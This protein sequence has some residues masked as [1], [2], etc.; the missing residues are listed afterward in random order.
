MRLR[1]PFITRFLLALSAVLAMM[2]CADEFAESIVGNNAGDD[3]NSGCYLCFQVL[4]NSD[5]SQTRATTYD[6]EHS[7]EAKDGDFV[8]GNEELEQK[9]DLRSSFMILFDSGGNLFAEKPIRQLMDKALLEKDGYVPHP[10]DNGYIE[11]G[12]MTKIYP[13]LKAKTKEEKWPRQCLLVLNAP[14]MY[15]KLTKMQGENPTLEKILEIVWDGDTENPEKIG[16]TSAGFF[17]MTNAVYVSDEKVHVAAQIEDKHIELA[18]KIAEKRDDVDVI[19][20]DPEDEELKKLGDKVIVV[21]PKEMLRIRV[22]RMVAKFSFA[23]KHENKHSD[24]FKEEEGVDKDLYF[25]PTR[26]H[27]LEPLVFF[28]GLSEDGEIIYVATHHW[29][30]R[31]TGWGINALETKNHLFKQIGN[32]TNVKE[33]GG[34]FDYWND[35]QHYRSYWSEDPHYGNGDKYP[36]QYRGAVE[37]GENEDFEY[38]EKGNSPL[39]NYSYGDFISQTYPL[40]DETKDEFDRIV[41]TP[42]NTYGLDVIGQDLDNRTNL[43]AGT[44][45]IVTAQLEVDLTDNDEY[46][47]QDWY[48]DR[49][50]IYYKSERDCFVAFAHSFNQLLKSQES[51][52][53]PLYNWGHGGYK[54]PIKDWIAKPNKG[55]DVENEGMKYMLYYEDKPLTNSFL[56]K[57]VNDTKDENDQYIAGHIDPDEFTREYGNLTTANIL[58]GDSKLLPW[59]ENADGTLR[60]KIKPCSVDEEGNVY[61]SGSTVLQI[62]EKDDDSKKGGNGLVEEIIPGKKRTSEYD[63]SDATDD[64]IKSLFYDWVGAVDRF[65]QGKMYY[66]APVLHNGVNKKKECQSQKTLGD[67]GVVRN[68]W[69]QFQLS[70]II[71][72]GI[73]VDDPTKPIV[74]NPV[75]IDDVINFTVKI[76]DWHR[77]EWNVPILD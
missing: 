23:N 68:N 66:A 5:G 76:I 75:S 6:D 47:V 49:S 8:H 16:R 4:A 52:K 69:Y 29:R 53:Y 39:K 60:L 44:H 74:P 3:D 31:V 7:D 54:F 15:E 36:W 71:N 27:K 43:L 64:D 70:D 40:D 56:T 9:I 67:Y 77:F 2:S 42:E 17:T 1:K 59:F 63:G 57:L 41:Y 11:A 10:D 13:N 19:V 28:E 61:K 51:M 73:P 72:I 30:I 55:Y 65:K 50:G 14:N 12:Y 18:E 33:N 24:E 46:V 22:E 45:L 58:Y 38:Y 48:R 32:L 34:Y 20:G 26:D 25:Y 62:Y 35:S 21:D 37:R